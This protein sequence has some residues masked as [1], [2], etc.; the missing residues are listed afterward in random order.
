VPGIDVVGGVRGLGPLH[1]RGERAYTHAPRIL[2]STTS[3]GVPSSV[4]SGVSAGIPIGPGP[5]GARAG[6]RGA[7]R[8]A[9]VS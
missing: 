6:S 7:Y 4:T 3:R 9:T 2:S 1:R 8:T 5:I